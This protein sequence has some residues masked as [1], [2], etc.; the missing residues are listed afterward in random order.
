MGLCEIR[1]SESYPSTEDD[2]EY[3]HVHLPKHLMKN[4][5]QART[6]ERKELYGISGIRLGLGWEHYEVWSRESHILLLRRPRLRKRLAAPSG[7]QMPPEAASGGQPPAIAAA[8]QGE[9]GCEQG[10]RPPTPK[11][12]RLRKKTQ[13]SRKPKER[14][15][16][17]KDIIVCKCGKRVRRDNFARHQNRC[18]PARKRQ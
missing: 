13:N 12:F 11:R 17:Y 5:P 1:Y 9:P 14:W 7:T 6:L 15:L 10:G 2:Y 4:L 3:R 16:R 8:Q 18:H